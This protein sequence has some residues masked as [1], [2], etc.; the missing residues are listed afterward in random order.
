MQLKS[1]LHPIHRGDFVLCGGPLIVNGLTI[2]K[3]YVG[4]DITR[5][6]RISVTMMINLSVANILAITSITVIVILIQIETSI[7]CYNSRFSRK[8]FPFLFEMTITTFIQYQISKKTT[9]LYNKQV[10]N[11]SHISLSPLIP[12]NHWAYSHFNL[13]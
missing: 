7:Y 11:F 10:K 1:L 3:L 9:F 12:H 5:N 2:G 6:Q 4:L 13:D 8:S